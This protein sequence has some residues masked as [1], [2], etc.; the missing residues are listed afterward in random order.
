MQA[1]ARVSEEYEAQKRLTVAATLAAR[2]Q[3]GRMKGDWWSSFEE[4]APGLEMIVTASQVAA[5]RQGAAYV[6]DVLEE[7]GQ[8]PKAV[9]RVNTNALAGTASDGRPLESLLGMAVVRSK[10]AGDLLAGQ[11]FLDSVV[12]TQI[13]DAH[14][15]SIQLGTIARPK[16]GWVRMVNTPC[17]K[18]CALLA[19]RF[20][21]AND[22]FLR[23]P[24]CKCYHLPSTDP[25]A[26]E[27]TMPDPSEITGL[28]E[29]E[30]KALEAGGDYSQVIN[31]A[32][33]RNRVRGV[34]VTDTSK[35]TTTEGTTRR[36]TAYKAM[37]G[38]RSRDVRRKGDRYFSTQK[39]RLTP[40]GI[41][42]IASTPE[43]ARR[44][45]VANGYLLPGVPLHL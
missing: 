27:G 35:M 44:L 7:Q 5:A 12:S 20:Y 11:S 40:D 39:R 31:A 8:R 36:G 22:G 41:Y 10:R 32:R 17:C 15:A 16:T 33:G 6:P 26:Y 4:V 45:L 28:T 25:N 2:E 19:G 43:E 21:K 23:H 3:W 18:D 34:R 37:G 24:N 1:P 30:R 13:A 14:R 42:R 38:G 29:G 9:A